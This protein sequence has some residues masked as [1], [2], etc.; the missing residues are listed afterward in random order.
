MLHAIIA[1]ANDSAETT[2]PLDMVTDFFASP[3]WQ[4]LIYLFF[5]CLV[6]VWLA[7][8][9]WI[10]KDARRRIEDPIVI[11]VC[12]LTGLV[13]GPTGWLVYSI[14]RPSEFIADRR[15]RELDTQLI[16]QRLNEEARCTYCKAPV[17]DDYLVCP[18]C[19]RRLRTQCRSCH[20]PLEPSWR[21]CPYCEADTHPAGSYASPDKLL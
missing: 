16:E 8:A 17:R 7:G 18:S 10:Y 13:F 11:G 15:L 2:N 19:G 4:F 5:F 9:Y 3:L 1:A 20:R 21:V 14:A 6:A 12:V